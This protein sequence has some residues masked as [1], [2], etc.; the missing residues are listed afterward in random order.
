MWKFININTL[1][2]LF[3][4]YNCLVTMIR[5]NTTMIDNRLIVYWLNCCIVLFD[6]IDLIVLIWLY[7]FDWINLIILFVYFH[8][9]VT[10]YASHHSGWSCH[11]LLDC[12]CA[13]TTSYAPLYLIVYL[14][15]LIWLFIFWL[16]IYFWLFWLGKTNFYNF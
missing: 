9:F 10:I 2:N 14:I 16:I 6:C 15:E 12:V 7:W 5:Y 1:I 3:D 11:P 8:L 4:G 13:A